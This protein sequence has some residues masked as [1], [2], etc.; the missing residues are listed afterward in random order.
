MLVI[1]KY[2]F[3]IGKYTLVIGKYTFVIGKYTFVMVVIVRNAEVHMCYRE[4]IGK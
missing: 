3:V 4:V 1:G 2:T